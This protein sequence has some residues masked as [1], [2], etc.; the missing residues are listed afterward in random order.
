MATNGAFQN[1]AAELPA[2]GPAV[3]PTAASGSNGDVS[4]D[5]VGWFFV[6]QYYTTLSKTPEKLHVSRCTA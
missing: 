3:D 1:Q 5:E 4:K 6:A 2:G